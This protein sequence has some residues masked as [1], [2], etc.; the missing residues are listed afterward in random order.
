MS[1]QLDLKR[2]EQTELKRD[3]LYQ[4]LEYG[5]AGALEHQGAELIGFRIRYAVF[6]CLMTITAD[7]EG[8]RM[9]CHVGSDSLTNCIL[10]ATSNASNNQLRWS[11]CKYFKNK[12]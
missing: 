3:R 2:E 4:A 5:L 10:R 7:F 1:R 6:D 8:K 12:A 11:P 9:V